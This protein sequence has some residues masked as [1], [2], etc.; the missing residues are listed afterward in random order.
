MNRMRVTPYEVEWKNVV[1]ATRVVYYLWFYPGKYL[2][3]T[4]SVT[5]IYLVYVIMHDAFAIYLND[6][7]VSYVVFADLLVNFK[8][9]SIFMSYVSIKQKTHILTFFR[10]VQIIVTSRAQDKFANFK[11]SFINMKFK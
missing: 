8:S 7:Q 1:K 5:R 3:H 11:N 6:I 10:N 2:R 4:N 9:C